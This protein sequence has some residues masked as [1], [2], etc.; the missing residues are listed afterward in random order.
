MTMPSEH[1]REAGAVKLEPCTLQ[2][3]FLKIG[4]IEEC[5]SLFLMETQNLEKGSQNAC[6]GKEAN[7]LSKSKREL[8]SSKAG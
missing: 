4:L 3:I 5:E 7:V 6:E 8:D 1:V 2:S